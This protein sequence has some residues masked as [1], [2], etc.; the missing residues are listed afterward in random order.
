[1]TKAGF[2]K[3]SENHEALRQAAYAAWQ[4]FK[5][6]VKKAYPIDR[7][8]EDFAQIRLQG[9]PGAAQRMG[10]CPFHNETN[11]S[12]SVRPQDGFFCCHSA[13]CGV[14]G[15]VF[16]FI[17]EYQGVPFKQAV[18]MAA[19]KV[20]I[21]PPNGERIVEFKGTHVPRP[22]R[23]AAEMNPAKLFESDLIPAFNKSRPPRAGVLFPVWHPGGGMKNQDPMLKR[24]KPEMVHIYRNMDGWPIS[25]VLRCRHTTGGKY[26]MPIRIGTLPPEA[27]NDIVDQKKDRLGWMV[28][29]T[30]AGHRKPIYGME[31]ARKWIQGGGTRILIVEGE[32]TCDA[33]ERLIGD[34]EG[35]EDWLVLSPMGGHN[36][37]LYADWTAFMDL[38]RE[39]G[40]LEGVSLSVWPDADR[41]KELRDG[42][43]RDPQ[44]IYVRDS[45]GAFV[46]AARRAELDP[47]QMSFNRAL[48][49]NHLEEGWDL[50]DAED[51]GWDGEKLKMT[52]DERGMTMAIEPRFMKMDVT[53]ESE[54]DPTPFEDGSEEIDDLTLAGLD[55]DEDEVDGEISNEVAF[56]LD[57][58]AQLLGDDVNETTDIPVMER[59]IEDAEFIDQMPAIEGGEVI[60]PGNDDDDIVNEEDLRAAAVARNRHFR[61]LGYRDCTNYF[62]SLVSGQIFSI[63]YGAM[64]KAA[65]LSLAPLRFWEATFSDVGRDGRMVIDWDS[66]CSAL[67][68]RAYSAGYWDPMKEAGQGARI[69]LGRVV[70]NTGDSLWVQ[71]GEDGSGVLTMASEFQGE[72]HYTIGDSC[73]LPDFENAFDATSHEPREL[74]SLIGKINWRDGTSQLS[75]M[76]LFGWLCIGPICGVLPWRPHLWLDGQRAAGKS[77]IIDNI[78]KPVLG[79]YAIRVKLNST[80]SGLRNILHSRAFPLVFDEAEGG[81]DADRIRMASIMKLARH[82]AT[83]GDSIVAQ[84]V[85]GGNGQKFFSIAS[86]FLLASITPQL[87][88]SADKTRFAR[89]KLGP[90]HKLNY[91]TRELERPARELLTPTFSARM[92]ARMVMRAGSIGVV[93]AMMV[94][95]LTDLGLERRLADVFGTFAAGAWLLL[96]D[97][98]PADSDVAMAWIEET[99]GIG[100]EIREFSDEITE[101]KDHVRLFRTIMAHEVRCET[102]NLGTRYY[103]IGSIIEMAVQGVEENEDGLDVKQANH[104]L[105][106]IGIR[107][108][109]GEKLAKEGDP[110]DGLFIHKNS[111][112]IHEILARTPYATSYID[113]MQ[114]AENVKKGPSIRFGGLGTSR[115]EIVPLRYFLETDDEGHNAN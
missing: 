16:R 47:K 82:S 111:P 31:K 67:I 14:K 65:L 87:E 37:S 78:I 41:I 23:A 98:V 80:E 22:S 21:E 48:P 94:H 45:I 12:M 24:Y 85:A 38:M 73:G 113:V 58:T 54:D 42:T 19:E 102:L 9:Q 35:A 10:C 8:I 49:G 43:R 52:L 88:D 92:I 57:V 74:L 81:V 79:H 44:E 56:T 75:I 83:P 59:A 17:S 25:V 93:Q 89:A 15:D 77:W 95:A 99:F 96:E 11:P 108:A 39:R 63:H 114:Q 62:M 34:L 61:C 27:P 66:A 76:A 100:S 68:E 40:T 36:A 70:F 115:S 30:T 103:N 72:Y 97:D 53:L 91:F 1:M 29:G 86:T 3:K 84:G 64:R 26:F 112:R 106:N 71:T 4:D 32:K 110:I 101:D 90:G 13:G 20:G 33:A 51:E 18:L 46:I 105:M 6:R 50:A 5:L 104:H 2:A 60:Q 69:D 28:K 7:A 107:L 109:S 55:A